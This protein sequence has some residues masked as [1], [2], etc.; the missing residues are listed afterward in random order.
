MNRL[1]AIGFLLV[2]VACHTQPKTEQIKIAAVN[3]K[4]LS[5]TGCA[6][7]TKACGGCPEA[8][9]AG[10]ALAVSVDS[11]Q[12]NPEKYFDKT[13]ALQGRVIHTCKVSGKK[14]FLAGS[15][16]ENLIRI[17]A[18]D[19]I[20]RFDESLQGEIVIAKGMLTPV[21]EI[22]ADKEKDGKTPCVTEAK[23]Q[24]YVLACSEFQVLA[25]DPA[26]KN[27]VKTVID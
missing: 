9:K 14:M 5:I 8:A 22:V 16:Q 3:E 1:S 6:T 13:I 27:K 7:P 25:K 12:K 26:D 11:V 24:Q 10:I 18:G 19:N 4:A 17:N 15:D 21:N 20:S 23:A 2:F